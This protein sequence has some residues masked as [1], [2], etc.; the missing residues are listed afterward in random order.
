M[1]R[2]CG[3]GMTHMRPNVTLR[4]PVKGTALK[5][6]RARKRAADKTLSENAYKARWR[7]QDRCR[8]CGSGQGVEVHHIAFRSQGGTHDTSNL[9]CLCRGCH[10]QVHARRIWLSGDA[11]GVMAI[12]GEWASVTTQRRGINSER[13]VSRRTAPRPSP[14]P[15]QGY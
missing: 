8:V 3:H 12:S 5:A 2:V 15:K 7:D 4:K 13:V 6:R 1:T 11:D 9:V 10:A 14:I